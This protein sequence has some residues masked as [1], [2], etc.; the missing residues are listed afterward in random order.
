M[1]TFS[2]EAVALQG[3]IINQADINTC[4]IKFPN[5]VLYNRKYKKAIHSTEGKN[6]SY[7]GA[8]LLNFAF[9]KLL[10][11]CLVFEYYEN[12]KKI[13]ELDYLIFG[14][15]II[16]VVMFSVY[17]IFSNVTSGFLH[18]IYLNQKQQ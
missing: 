4:S 5:T 7:C 15:Q 10:Y 9:W 11:V 18:V 2:L 3:L 14:H 8:K 16:L 17:N 13:K 1:A 6:E 12:I